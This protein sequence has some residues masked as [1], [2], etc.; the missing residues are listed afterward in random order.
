MKP[1]AQQKFIEGSIVGFDLSDS[2]KTNL[3]M[4]WLIANDST[5]VIYFSKQQF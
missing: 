1:K 3:C 5:E 4:N 2:K